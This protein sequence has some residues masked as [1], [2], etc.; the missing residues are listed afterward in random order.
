MAIVNVKHVSHLALKAQSVEQQTSFYTSMVGLGETRRDTSGRVY[1]RCT[2]KMLDTFGPLGPALVTRDEVAD[3][4]K[5]SI[6]TI[7]NGEVMQDGNTADMIFGVP[8]IVSY[9]SEITT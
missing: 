6:K 5:L 7:L 1:L 3:P 9:I 2:G 4:N 8:H